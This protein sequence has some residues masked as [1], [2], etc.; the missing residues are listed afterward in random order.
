[1]TILANAVQAFIDERESLLAQ[2]R[3][4]KRGIVEGAG[5]ALATEGDR[6]A[7]IVEIERKIT[8]I[9]SYLSQRP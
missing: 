2:L 9:D 4:T 5:Q 6:T 8:A 1:M 7:R 3:A